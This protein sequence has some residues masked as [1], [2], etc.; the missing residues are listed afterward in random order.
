[1]VSGGKEKIPK[2]GRSG[3]RWEKHDTRS[4][5]PALVKKTHRSGEDTS[6]N[7][8]SEKSKKSHI[9]Q[10]LWVRQKRTRLHSHVNEREL[11]KRVWC[12]GRIE[13]ELD[14]RG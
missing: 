7:G 8:S 11:R 9:W 14:S 12:F 4:G 13:G 2:S 10:A 3:T 5:K 1:M 6:G